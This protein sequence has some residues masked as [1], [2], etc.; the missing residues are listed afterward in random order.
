MTT[1]SHSKLNTFKQCP[2]R[3]KYKYID[4]IKPEIEKT[5]EAHL[6]TAVHNTLEWLYYQIKENKI[7]TIEEMI[8]QYSEKW[9]QDFQ[10]NILIVKKH[11][12]SRDYFNQGVQFL[13]EYYVKNYPFDENTIA[14]EKKIEF[15][16]DKE[17]NHKLIGYIDRLVHNKETGNYEIHD[18]KTAN[19]L[20]SQEKV[21]S[22][23]QLALYSIAIKELFGKE[24]NV[25]LIWHYLAH[26]QK[27]CSTRTNEQLEKLK[28]NILKLIDKIESGKDFKA[29]QTKLCGWCEYKNI[30]P[31]FK[32]TNQFKRY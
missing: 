7:P 5:I 14:L 9:I 30:C 22:D 6:G 28:Q 23:V 3:F 11:L 21:D 20:P 16:L 29:N 17:K 19:S 15:I 13:T 31:E 4:K 18:Y 8:M 2:L 12:T 1:Y 32:E 10:E 24:N 26:N 25:L 27:I